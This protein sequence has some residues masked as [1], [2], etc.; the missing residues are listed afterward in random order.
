MN[1]AAESF[2]LEAMLNYGH[3]SYRLTRGSIDTETEYS[4]QFDFARLDKFSFKHWPRIR[5]PEVNGQELAVFVAR[6]V[7]QH[8]DPYIKDITDLQTYLAFLTSDRE[9]YPWFASNPMTRA[10]Q[11]VAVSRQLGLSREKIR[12]LLRPYDDSI[13]RGLARAARDANPSVDKYI[14]NLLLDWVN[15]PILK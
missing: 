5:V 10:A 7:S 13:M 4:M 9:P 3:I 12:D 8:L 6:F 11:V 15:I 2:G 1:P 14:D